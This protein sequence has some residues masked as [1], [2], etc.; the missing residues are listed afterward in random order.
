MKMLPW[1]TTEALR[2]FEDLN[3]CLLPIKSLAC[4]LAYE[5]LTSEFLPF[6]QSN[7]PIQR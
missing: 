5:A 7:T 2:E 3:R 4:L 1:K 6:A